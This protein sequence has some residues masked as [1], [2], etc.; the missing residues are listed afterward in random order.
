MPTINQ[1]IRKG[2]VSKVENSKSPALNKGYNSFKKSTLT[3]L[4]H[5]NAGYVLVSVQ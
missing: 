5:K 4:L 1:L 2:R 3:Y